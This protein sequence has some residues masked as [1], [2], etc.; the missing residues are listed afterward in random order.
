MIV[1]DRIMDSFIE[2]SAVFDEMLNTVLG[3]STLP[4][5]YPLKQEKS[6]PLTKTQMT[7][8]ATSTNKNGRET[9]KRLFESGT[10]E[11]PRLIYDV[12]RLM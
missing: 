1:F 9:C 8:N 11:D 12:R 2:N 3:L 5:T 4:S 6:F 7:T 10:Y